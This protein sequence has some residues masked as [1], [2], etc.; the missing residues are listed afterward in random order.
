MRDPHLTTFAENR[1]NLFFACLS[2]VAHGLIIPIA[3]SLPALLYSS[4]VGA[5]A[6]QSEPVDMAYPERLTIRVVNYSVTTELSDI[7]SQS[8]DK[9][10][11]VRGTVVRVSN[12]KPLLLKIGIRCAKCSTIWMEY[13]KDGVP[14]PPMACAR[15]DC[16]CRDFQ[17]VREYA[18][19]TDWQ[20]IRLQEAA[21]KSTQG[22]IPITKEVEVVGEEV[23]KCVPGDVV[24]VVG[25]VRA[26]SVSETRGVGS[27]G[28]GR[29]GVAIAQRG[30]GRGGAK[31]AGQAGRGGGGGLGDSMAP[32]KAKAPIYDTYIEA[33]SL[34]TSRSGS[35]SG[36][37]TNGSAKEETR[38]ER[39]KD[40]SMLST[41]D[42][43]GVLQI[44]NHPSTFALIV[45]SV[46]PVIYGHELVKAGLVLALFG[47]SKHF[48]E[49][50]NN[51]V[52][53]RS[54][55]HVLI[56]GDPGLG[57]SQ[58]LTSVNKLAPRGVYVC[59]SYAS[60]AGLTVSTQR[61]PGSHDYTLEAG[62]LVLA[63]NGIA[64]IDEL[65][66]MPNDLDALLEAMEQQQ[67]SIAKAGIVCSLPARATIIAAANPRQGHYDKT[68]TIS[69][70][71]NMSTALLSRF[72]LIFVLLDKPDAER[73]EK[74]SEH[75]F[76][77]HTAEHHLS[78]GNQVYKEFVVNHSTT[79]PGQQPQQL[80]D[81]AY[82]EASTSSCSQSVIPPPPSLHQRL[83]SYNPDSEQGILTPTLLS[84][85]ISYA[86]RFVRPVLTLQAKLVLQDFYM[87]LRRSHQSQDGTP[88]TT[89]Q[90]ESLIR[91][92]EAR[93]KVELRN[94][95][96]E[97]D[98]RDVI[99]IMKMSLRDALDADHGFET[100][101]LGTT[102][103]R[104]QQ[105][106]VHA[107]VKELQKQ[108]RQR[109]DADFTKSD[110]WA[111]AQQLK[112]IPASSF[113]D[114]IDSLNHQGYLLRNSN[115][116]WKVFGIG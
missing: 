18:V 111:I 113:E 44:A 1:P 90:L 81:T 88:V 96:T 31:K 89:R 50:H 108:A 73:D 112:F 26:V 68:K 40:L 56:V 57:K 80:M 3:G 70:N 72:D 115:K 29:S 66:K 78:H 33:N 58:M 37:G 32:S 102:G 45:A 59:G 16:G 106:M 27:R 12:A 107:F 13:C 41:M 43:Y 6:F 100:V 10:K 15:P 35:D 17:L 51:D 77:Q 52:A 103:R 4:E 54:D 98:A 79:L 11:S 84:R 85:Y 105:K 109:G 47:G 49:L 83:R 114:F 97:A 34:H 24:T 19:T 8:I 110:M 92:A 91:L 5:F 64:C 39:N 42:L 67:I 101:N 71:L 28:V 95:V 48:D 14:L 65:D 74:I 30:S 82:A 7:K 36:G 76:A 46:C 104:G 61:E 60:A 116:S 75:I 55:V 63:N 99:E 23:D 22:R 20:K 69:E 53:L 25:V 86:K 38:A 87:S 93:A 21:E 9:L 94:E 2:H 62:A